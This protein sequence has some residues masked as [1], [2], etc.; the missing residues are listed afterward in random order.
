MPPNTL[1]LLLG[2]AAQALSGLTGAVANPARARQLLNLL[3][4][5]LPAAVTD[6]GLTGIDVGPVVS[7][8]SIILHSTAAE[9]KDDGLMMSRYADLLIAVIA[10][11]SD[12]ESKAKA[13]AAL[14]TIP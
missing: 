1:D 9:Q 4:W 8:L 2:E 12:L 5:D 10:L 7:K 14:A 3:G 6:I 11:V 13:V